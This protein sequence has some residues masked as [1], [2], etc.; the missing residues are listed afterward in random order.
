MSGQAKS[1]YS[2]ASFS[3]RSPGT[4]GTIEEGCGHLQAPLISNATG[5]V[6]FFQQR[7]IRFENN[8]RSRK[9]SSWNSDKMTKETV[10]I[11]SAGKAYAPIP[12]A[13]TGG[14]QLSGSGSTHSVDRQ[15]EVET[16]AKAIH[17]RYFGSID[18][19]R[20]RSNSRSSVSRS[21]SSASRP[22]SYHQQLSNVQQTSTCLD[23]MSPLMTSRIPVIYNQTQTKPNNETKT[24]TP[25]S[26]AQPMLLPIRPLSEFFTNP[27][28]LSAFHPPINRSNTAGHY[29]GIQG[30]PVPNPSGSS[31]EM[32][33]GTQEGQQS[34]EHEA[35][36]VPQ[37]DGISAGLVQQI[38]S[39]PPSAH[40]RQS[41]RLGAF[42]GGNYAVSQ[43]Q[44]KNQFIPD[45]Q[46]RFQPPPS[47]SSKKPFSDTFR[48]SYEDSSHSQFSNQTVFSYRTHLTPDN[49]SNI[50]QSPGVQ[51]NEQSHCSVSND[52]SDG[53]NTYHRQMAYQPSIKC[54][55]AVKSGR[56]G[57]LPRTNTQQAH[58]VRTLQPSSAQ[59]PIQHTSLAG[60]TVFTFENLGDE[61]PDLVDVCYYQRS[62]GTYSNPEQRVTCTPQVPVN[63]SVEV[64]SNSWKT[65]FQTNANNVLF[66]AAPETPHTA[67][68]ENSGCNGNRLVPRSPVITRKKW[69][70]SR[71][72]LPT[73]TPQNAPRGN[74]LHEEQIHYSN[75]SHQLTLG[76]VQRSYTSLPRQKRQ[77][78]FKRNN[79]LESEYGHTFDTLRGFSYEVYI[80]YQ[81]NR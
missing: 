25:P 54:E 53:A 10:F 20:T 40:V 60:A 63:D 67:H 51:Y 47:T 48:H 52:P 59:N 3:T 32:E 35:S 8:L 64:P 4:L 21:T 46:N 72:Q 73:S 13:Y 11:N 81:Y 29:G 78:E 28:R 19:N 77:N 69:S 37:R 66:T 76:A 80:C 26:G 43:T 70:S 30:N 57:S 62:A 68:S 38:P 36:S 71:S 42:Y 74:S 12:Q 9:E 34:Y 45:A 14:Q 44:N 33:H 18:R 75:D 39:Q 27:G 7:Q 24:M 31:C 16:E 5:N 55:V 58:W 2:I 65:G 50:Y 23:L 15:T 49:S 1:R 41:S 56:E 79:T 6:D 17:E 22:S 61:Q